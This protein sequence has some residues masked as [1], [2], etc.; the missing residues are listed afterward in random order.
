MGALVNYLEEMLGR[1]CTELELVQ[2][3]EDEFSGGDLL[4]DEL[5]DHEWAV[6]QAIEREHELQRQI[7]H[8][9][10]Q[11][12]A[13]RETLRLTLLYAH[14]GG[15]Y[16]PDEAGGADV[17]EPGWRA[18]ESLRFACF[19]VIARLLVRRFE[20]GA[21]P[22]TDYPSAVSELAARLARAPIHVP[23]GRVRSSLAGDER[24]L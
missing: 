14:R 4:D 1:G 3:V 17:E 19:A 10:A 7:V 2:A 9:S 18:R 24:H 20:S 5:A 6:F 13:D 21:I 11:S 22:A 15:L 12:A 23:R 16:L 8:V